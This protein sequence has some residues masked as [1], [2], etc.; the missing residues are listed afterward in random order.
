MAD[1]GAT[2]PSRAL[3]PGSFGCEISPFSSPEGSQRSGDCP[4]RKFWGFALPTEPGAEQAPP[5]VRGVPPEGLLAPVLSYRDPFPVRLWGQKGSKT[6]SL[7]SPPCHAVC[8][9]RDGSRVGTPS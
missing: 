1:D 4:S 3:C 9:G 7:S 2:R 6:A 8:R 5:R